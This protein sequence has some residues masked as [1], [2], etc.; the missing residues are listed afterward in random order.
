MALEAD[1]DLHSSL[2][3]SQLDL[4]SEWG[5]ED[6]ERWSRVLEDRVRARVSTECPSR[7]VSPLLRVRL[8]TVE[9][10]EPSALLSI[11]RPDPELTKILNTQDAVVTI[12]N[13][14]ASGRRGG[15][16]C[17]NSTKQTKIVE[18]CPIELNASLVRK[19]TP[20]CSLDDSNF[21]PIFN[22]IDLVGVVSKV[23]SV[24][25]NN[26]QLVT[27]CD[28][29]GY[30]VVICFWGGIEAHGLTQLL[31]PGVSISATNLQCRKGAK[32]NLPN[33]L[34]T[35]P[36]LHATESS[37]FSRQP[38]EAY[39]KEAL[40]NLRA[41]LDPEMTIKSL[42]RCLTPTLQKPVIEKVVEKTPCREVQKRM[43]AL[44]RYGE[45]PPL[46]PFHT[47]QPPRV[48]FQT[49]RPPTKV[50]ERDSPPLSLSQ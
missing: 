33:N 42:K 40:Q 29:T 35:L 9:E 38:N 13:I 36:C 10:T 16:L 2:T 21:K 4:A 23:D 39:L 37:Q 50:E 11:W 8:V 26:S 19:V 5:R 14:N 1:P 25:I 18:A 49:F 27:L 30:Q 15:E 32:R 45:P 22:E 28:A 7:S 24:Q 41:T 48:L 47:P 12:Y 6:R 3:E 31:I 17:L 46:S 44:S 34:A 20:I 43:S